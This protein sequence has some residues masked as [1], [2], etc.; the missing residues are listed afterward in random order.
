MNPV[1]LGASLYSSSHGQVPPLSLGLE[2]L[3][4][5]EDSPLQN[6]NPSSPGP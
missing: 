4:C 1:S 5:S 3:G 2:V 6:P